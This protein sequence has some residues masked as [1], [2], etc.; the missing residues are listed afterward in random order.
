MLYNIGITVTIRGRIGQTERNGIINEQKNTYSR[1]VGLG[2]FSSDFIKL[3]GMHPDVEG[4][5]GP[6]T[7]SRS[8]SR[9]R[10]RSTV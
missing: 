4:G 8:A 10:G 2:A 1:V 6:V 9:N 3:F 5:R 7:F